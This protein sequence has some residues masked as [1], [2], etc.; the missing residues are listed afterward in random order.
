MEFRFGF[1]AAITDPGDGGSEGQNEA[2][3]VRGSEGGPV[4][5]E[6]VGDGRLIR[7][8]LATTVTFD[9]RC[10]HNER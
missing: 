6:T 3:R 7:N 4:T 1:A 10:F 9:P 5:R 8:N 2:K